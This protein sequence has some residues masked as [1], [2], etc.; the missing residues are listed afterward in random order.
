MNF[1]KWF[2]KHYK[3]DT[4]NNQMSVD[5]GDGWAACKKEVLK[6]LDKYHEGKDTDGFKYINIEAL[7]KIEKL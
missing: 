1:E 6:I 2:Y 7:E 4:M 5:S 3:V